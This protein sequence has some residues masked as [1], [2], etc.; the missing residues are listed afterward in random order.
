MNFEEAKAFSTLPSTELIL[1]ARQEFQNPQFQ[2]RQVL[3]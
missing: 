1:I 3:N 2:E